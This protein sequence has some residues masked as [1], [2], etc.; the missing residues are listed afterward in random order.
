MH[1]ELVEGWMEAE[2]SGFDRLGRRFLVGLR[3]LKMMVTG[4]VNEWGL[5]QSNGATE[6]QRGGACFRRKQVEAEI[7]LTGDWSLGE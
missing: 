7:S 2:T 3:S 4:D 6:R 1:P 5:T